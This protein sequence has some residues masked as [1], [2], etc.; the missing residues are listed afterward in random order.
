MSKD[1]IW[2]SPERVRQFSEMAPDVHLAALLERYDDCGELR[3]LDVGCAGGRNTEILAGAGCDFY[4]VDMA[5]AMVAA[6][7]ERLRPFMS[8]EE[9]A[10]RVSVGNMLRLPFEDAWFDL[11]IAIGVFHQAETDEELRRAL[12]E[13]RR[14]LRRR[15]R[16]LAAIF[17]T[18][19][20]SPEARRMPGQRFIYR[21][22][23]RIRCRVSLEEWAAI[24]AGAGFAPEGEIEVR[25]SQDPDHMRVSFVGIFT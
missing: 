5:H 10:R 13:A 22:G 1:D 9:F 7:R 3:A 19:M 6:T 16:M 21:D 24:C 14:V 23:E 11:L 20:L 12:Q 25:R 4:A 18:E 15:G 2:N 17:S 8:G